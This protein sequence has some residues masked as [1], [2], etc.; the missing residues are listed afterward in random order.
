M[1]PAP[2]GKPPIGLF[3]EIVRSGIR[4]IRDGFVPTKDENYRVRSAA[5]ALIANELR[6]LHERGEAPP[7]F[8]TRDEVFDRLTKQE[9]VVGLNATNPDGDPE[10]GFNIE[11]V[12]RDG[13][14]IELEFE[15]SYDTEGTWDASVN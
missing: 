13:L 6:E 15:K 3:V 14:A 11:M 9:W 12:W 2:F 10:L 7:F 5:G 8:A 1:L 4:L